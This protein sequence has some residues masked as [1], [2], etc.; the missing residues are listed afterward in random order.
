MGQNNILLKLMEVLHSTVWLMSPCESLLVNFCPLTGSYIRLGSI[1]V[2]IKD[3]LE[4]V[5]CFRALLVWQCSNSYATL[6]C[7]WHYV[8]VT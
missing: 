6:V 3:S 4:G 2:L 7:L 5:T 8:N 1:P